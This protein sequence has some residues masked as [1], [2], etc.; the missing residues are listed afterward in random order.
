MFVSITKGETTNYSGLKPNIF[1][2]TGTFIIKYVVQQIFAFKLSFGIFFAGI[3]FIMSFLKFPL[4][5]IQLR[6]FTQKLLSFVSI[7]F[8]V[9]AFIELHL[10]IFMYLLMMLTIILVSRQFNYAT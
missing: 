4:Q 2:K 5:I 1:L 9:L 10:F 3:S 8:F 6:S 7:I